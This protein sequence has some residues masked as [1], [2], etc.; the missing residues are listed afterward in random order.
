VTKKKYFV[1]KPKE[2]NIG[3]LKLEYLKKNGFI[4][5]IDYKEKF[6]G[7]LNQGMI[8]NALANTM[9]ITFEVTESCNLDCEYCGYGD[10]YSGKNSQ[11][12]NNDLPINYAINLI[13]FLFNLWS[14]SEN[15]SIEKTLG[16]S[17]YGGEPLLKIDF[18]K[19]VLKHINNIKPKNIIPRYSITTNALLLKKHISFLIENEFHLL[20]SLD[21]NKINNSYRVY[22]NKR[23]AFAKIIEN[24]DF[25]YH[26]YPDYFKNNINFN[27]VLHNRNSVD[28][29]FNYIYKKYNKKTMLSELNTYGI[30]ESKK[31]EF[32]N[33]Y[34]NALDSLNHSKDYKLIREQLFI[35]S[36]D[37]SI[38]SSF[39]HSYSNNIYKTYL[40]F[41]DFFDEKD[42]LPTATCVPFSRKIF[43]TAKGKILQ[44]EKITDKIPLGNVNEK[45]VK[46]DYDFIVEKTN[47]IYEKLKKYCN[48]CNL[49][50]TCI[51][52]IFNLDLSTNKIKCPE[53]KPKSATNQMF[54]YFTNSLINDRTLYRK[55][56]KKIYY[57]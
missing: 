8:K 14:S 37:I 45:E 28:D 9:H 4:E 5:N 48:K 36:P 7:R 12:G 2:N 22:K 3:Q 31:V 42:C 51:L 18:M 41:F 30:E 11:R 25:V 21:G 40:D 19:D 6:S 24:I 20:I 47:H 32:G 44:C 50:R 35:K 27:S 39:M 57:E 53:F 49:A 16:I 56:L 55:I 10:F 52:C 17:F 34:N 13:N 23:E 54:D 29:A 43:L 38:I 15:K 26:N 46:I 33:K 1:L